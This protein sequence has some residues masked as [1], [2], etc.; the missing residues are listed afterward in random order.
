MKIGSK[1]ALYKLK[2]EFDTEKGKMY[3]ATAVENFQVKTPFGQV[4]EQH[5][6]NNIII[7]TDLELEIANFDVELE[8]K[9]F[10]RKD[11]S[12]YELKPSPLSFERISNPEKSIIRVIDFEYRITNQRMKNGRIIYKQGTNS[13]N[14]NA[15][16]AIYKCE[17]DCVGWCMPE[18]SCEKKLK[19][20]AKGNELQKSKIAELKK[21]INALKKTEAMAMPKPTTFVDKNG[22]PIDLPT[23]DSNEFI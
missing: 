16:F 8:P 18:K 14:E 13:P 11:G 7:Y 6:I 20:Y 22:R 5:F 15:V 2:L 19:Y 12:T 9:T 4:W 17:Y 1:L 10:L 23:F 3:K 21:E